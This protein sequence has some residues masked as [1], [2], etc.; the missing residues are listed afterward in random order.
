TSSSCVS[1]TCSLLSIAD[2]VAYAKYSKELD[3]QS[4]R[5]ACGNDSM[6][7]SIWQ[8]IDAEHDAD[9]DDTANYQYKADLT[10]LSNGSYKCAYEV[11]VGDDWYACDNVNAGWSADNVVKITNTTESSEI[12]SLAYTREGGVD[13]V[14]GAT[15][16]E[17]N[18]LYTCSDAGAWVAEEPACANGC[19][20]NPDNPGTYKCLDAAVD[21]EWVTIVDGPM[22]NGDAN[23]LELV[24]GSL[25]FGTK[26]V[27]ADKGY[28][29]TCHWTGIT[30]FSNAYMKYDFS[31][32]NIDA[33]DGKTKIGFSGSFAA[34]S[35]T[36][37]DKAKVA[38]YNNSGMIGEPCEVSLNDQ[39]QV[40]IDKDSCNVSIP[41]STDGLQIRIIGYP[42]VGA[43]DKACLRTYPFSISAM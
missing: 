15:K 13:C 31:D 19:G 39:T 40:F 7:V 26:S 3:V 23:I 33:L 27:L 41:E 43:T 20:E 37:L 9:N 2:N 30:D 17:T 4:S 11:K 32:A 36:K 5:V 6:L 29:N 16:C 42:K 18:N 34:Q 14:A 38:F 28:Y 12:K 22:T 1:I 21:P 24:E 25:T 35:S 8:S 10:S